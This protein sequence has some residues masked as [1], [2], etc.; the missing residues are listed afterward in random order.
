MIERYVPPV[1]EVLWKKTGSVLR[2][3]WTQSAQRN[4]YE[5]SKFAKHRSSLI[6]VRN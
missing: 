6:A 5:F 2:W 3:I 4:S 1:T